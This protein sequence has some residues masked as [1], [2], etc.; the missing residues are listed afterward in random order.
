MNLRKTIF[1]TNTIFFIILFGS[2]PLTGQLT[3]EN[4]K[5]NDDTQS[6][7]TIDDFDSFKDLFEVWNVG[8]LHVFAPNPDT[9]NKDYYFEG[10]IIEKKFRK[11]LPLE[12][13]RAMLFNDQK[14]YAVGIIRGNNNE[15]FYL[16]RENSLQTPNQLVLYESINNQLLAKR[17]I[18]YFKMKHKKYFQLDT[19]IQD[20]DGDTRLD[21][22]QRSRKIIK[23]RKPKDV[24]TKVFLQNRDGE[25]DLSK[26]YEIEEK[27][28]QFQDLNN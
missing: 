14:Y 8:N 28:Y 20:L 9:A 22:I 23:S 2:N 10:E 15:D 5:K 18:A 3:S 4:G 11:H 27:D 26:E 16:V 1:Y 21:L 7:I 17:V 13:Q 24:K 25:F 6:S 19:W 12:V